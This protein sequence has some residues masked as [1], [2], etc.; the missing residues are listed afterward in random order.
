MSA[1]ARSTSAWRSE[2]CADRTAA[3]ILRVDRI[4]LI[5]RLLVPSDVFADHPLRRREL[6]F[7]VVG[8]QAREHL[9]RAHAIA[10]LDEHLP[11][12][13]ARF[14]AIPTW[15]NGVIDAG[16][17]QRRAHDALTR[18]V[19]TATRGSGEGDAEGSARARPHPAHTAQSSSAAKHDIRFTKVMR[20]NPARRRLNGFPAVCR[21]TDV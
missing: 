16:D 20:S 1:P 3:A 5:R 21:E 2:A 12:G 13:S 6:R 4:G 17:L 10:L 9:T 14:A 15:R 7:E 19:T 18:R 11:I 8:E